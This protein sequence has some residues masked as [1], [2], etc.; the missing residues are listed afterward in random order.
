MAIFQYSHYLIMWLMGLLIITINIS[1]VT[2]AVAAAPVANTGLICFWF[3][4][5]PGHFANQ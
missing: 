2:P 5:L 1:I 3:S 4:W